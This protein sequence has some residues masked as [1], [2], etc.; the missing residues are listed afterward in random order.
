MR[1]LTAGLI[2][3]LIALSGVVLGLGASSS[4]AQAGTGHT[5]SGAPTDFILGT[6]EFTLTF[7]LAAQTP[8]GEVLT[9]KNVDPTGSWSITVPVQAGETQVVFLLR[10]A[11]DPSIVFGIS[12]PQSITAGGET[13]LEVLNFQEVEE[14]GKPDDG[15]GDGF[16]SVAAGGTDCDDSDASVFPGATEIAGDGIDQDCNGT[17]LPDGD[18]DGDGDGAGDGDG[19]GAGDG[20]GEQWEI[21]L[22]AGGQF[23]FW[24][25]G[26]VQA[27]NVFGVVKIAWLWNAVAFSWTS[28]VPALGVVNFSANEGDFLWVVT[29]GA[30]TLVIGEQGG[31]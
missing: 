13:E 10:D 5:F 27:A 31:D 8:G 21:E 2:A 18:G 25:H 17:D 22:K 26:P 20:S 29:F 23:V 15:D 4:P 7:N 3:G 14:K 30:L 1:P 16:D 28:F 6:S 11:Q 24:Q 12:A 9:S 19:D